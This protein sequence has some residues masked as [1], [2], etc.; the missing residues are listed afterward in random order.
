MPLIQPEDKDLIDANIRK[1]VSQSAIRKL[2]QLAD[3]SKWDD[4]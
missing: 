2:G 3:E 4:I 1:I